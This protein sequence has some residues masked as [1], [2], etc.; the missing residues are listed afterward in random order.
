MT[1]E[2]CVNALFLTK[3]PCGQFIGEIINL[4]IFYIYLFN[5][6]PYFHIDMI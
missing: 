3:V 4:T 5:L 2:F 1:R 6:Y